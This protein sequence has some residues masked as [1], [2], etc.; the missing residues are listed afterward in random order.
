MHIVMCQVV[1]IV[2]GSGHL[3]CRWSRL[4]QRRNC[5]SLARSAGRRRGSWTRR[6][7]R[8]VMRMIWTR[9]V[10][11]GRSC[12]YVVSRASNIRSVSV[13]L[14]L[15]ISPFIAHANVVTTDHFD[16]RLICQH[17]QAWMV[18][19]WSHTHAH[20][21][22]VLVSPAVVSAQVSLTFVVHH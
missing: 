9:W 7:R 2:Q 13:P 16:V 3:C 6:T 20:T 5:Q 11:G 1:N 12:G 15:F 14:F 19:A 21:W 17:C 10:V 22:L 8:A 18:C 4:C